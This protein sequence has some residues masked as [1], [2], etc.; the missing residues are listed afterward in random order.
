MRPL[1]IFWSFVKLSLVGWGGP[2]AR[3]ALIHEEFVRRQKWMTEK[4]FAKILAIYQVLPGPEAT[5]L[6]VYFGFK[7]KKHLGGVLS[8]LGFMLPGFILMLLAT[9]LYATYGLQLSV[10]NGFLYG[11]KPAALA[12]I[13]LTLMDIARSTVTNWK[14]ILLAAGATIAFM[15]NV[16]F[17][18]VLAIGGIV[19]WFCSRNNLTLI[20]ALPS[21]L[22]YTPLHAVFWVFLKA[23]LLTYGGAYSVVPFVYQE[24]VQK[25]QWLT[26][27][28]Y[29]DGLAIAQVLP[30]PL[31]IIGTF[32]GYFA[33]GFLGAVFATIGIFLPAFLFTLIGFN[34][35]ERL[36]ENKR[37]RTFL[38]GV[39]AAVIGLILATV[40]KLAGSAFVDYA[41]LTIGIIGFVLLWRKVNIAAVIIGSGLVGYF[42]H[43]L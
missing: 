1:Q 19:N 7:K 39:S 33:D 11:I 41:T 34:T 6:A 12:L 16:N 43:V 14:L 30:A 13:T 5:E 18:I 42:L 3:M 27:A 22:V 21:I 37:I 9:W 32:A 28:Q 23:G 2:V 29:L 15:F 35:I 25:F 20:F 10:F 8:G 31:S 26:T 36:A 40:L 17:V 38:E 24:A 4:H